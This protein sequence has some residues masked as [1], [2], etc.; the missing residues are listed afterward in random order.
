MRP[1]VRHLITFA[2]LLG[3]CDAGTTSP[4]DASSDTPSTADA[5]V[6]PDALDAEVKDSAIDVDTSPLKAE[7]KSDLV[8]RTVG[9]LSIKGDLYLPDRTTPVALVIMI[10]GGGFSDGDKADKTQTAWTSYLQAQGLAAFAVNYRV[11]ADFVNN[12][13]PFPAAPMDIK[14]AISWIR[15][16]ASTY[17]I[18]GSHI[19]VLGSSAGGF[20]SNFLGT[21]GDE[22]AFNPTDC[23]DGVTAS[24]RVQGVVTYFGPSDWNALFND[25]LRVGTDNGEK[26]F[27]GLAQGSTP[28]VPNSADAKGICKTASATNYAD[29]KDPPFFIAHSDDDPVVPVTQGRTMKAALEAVKVSVTYKEVTGLKHGWHSNFKDPTSTG[30]RDDVLAWLNAHK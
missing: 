4:V 17:R 30:V 5:S 28:C 2:L 25:P 9:N 8:F 6:Q 18:D 22:P 7:T 10:H 26:R 1:N 16:K 20:M 12:E 11:Y 14:C 21:T 3:G 19:F 15:A 13:V 24:N 23:A 27:I 29:A